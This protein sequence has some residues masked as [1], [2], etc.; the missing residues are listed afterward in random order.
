MDTQQLFQRLYSCLSEKY[1]RET[2][3]LKR[4]VHWVASQSSPLPDNLSSIKLVYGEQNGNF[5][6]HVYFD[7]RNAEHLKDRIRADKQLQLEKMK[8]AFESSP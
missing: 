2:L 6:V 4:F 5:S 7:Y 3:K 1:G 8:R